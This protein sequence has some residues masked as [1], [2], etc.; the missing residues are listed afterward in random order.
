MTERKKSTCKAVSMSRSSLNG[1]PVPNGKMIFDYST[2][3]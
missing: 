1:I 2:S 3:T